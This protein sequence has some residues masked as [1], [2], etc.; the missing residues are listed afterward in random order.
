ML[1][2]FAAKKSWLYDISCRSEIFRLF[3]DKN[4]IFFSKKISDDAIFKPHPLHPIA[5]IK[6]EKKLQK[7][8]IEKY[9]KQF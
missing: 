4:F 3:P 8:D 2:H 7:F 5:S 1:I 6:M 9:L